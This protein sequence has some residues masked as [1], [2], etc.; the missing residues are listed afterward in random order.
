VDGRPISVQR[1]LTSG[2]GA[3][4]Q[5]YD[6]LLAY[7]KG[8]RTGTASRV[9]RSTVR[10][11]RSAQ[12]RAPDPP[13]RHLATRATGGRRPLRA[14]GAARTMKQLH[15]DRSVGADL[16]IALH[17]ALT[18][19]AP[20][21]QLS[22]DRCP[23]GGTCVSEICRCFSIEVLYGPVSASCGRSQV[24]LLESAFLAA[25]R[26]GTGIATTGGRAPSWPLTRGGVGP[27]RRRAV[28]AALDAVPTRSPG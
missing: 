22:R 6:A 28:Q 16:S 2:G 25:P 12:R 23:G 7:R 27:L 10:S 14:Q 3:R 1:G 13:P 20:N 11:T 5:R 24:P 18:S 19:F 17:S 26:T 4:Q 21:S 9:G 8:G 15:A